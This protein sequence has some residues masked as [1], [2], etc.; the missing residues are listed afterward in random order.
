MS[1][2]V[3]WGQK[4]AFHAPKLEFQVVF[5][6]HIWVLVAE[7]SSGRGARALI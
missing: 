6:S 3:S 7:L 1:A 2:V 4:R 5:S